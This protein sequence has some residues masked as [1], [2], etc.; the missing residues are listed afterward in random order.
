MIQR[1]AIATLAAAT[2]ALSA[3]WAQP[4]QGPG[5]H[6]PQH[7][8]MQKKHG[9]QNKKNKKKKTMRSVFLIRHGLPHYSMI[10]MKM[11]DDP[12]LALTAEQKGKL[13][14]IRN[15]TV[16]QVKEIAPQV[17]KLT[18]E[19]VKGIHSG[20]KAES[21]YGK[22]DTLASLKAKATKVQLQCIEETKAVLTPEQLRYIKETMKQKR[23]K[24]KKQRG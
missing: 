9:Q 24:H 13:E 8:E 22:V 16:S 7:M 5:M 18:R 1:T 21:L 4:G 6:G 19:I 12:K 20:A 17:K 11:W 23:R 15:R 2:L 10:L 3:A 14:A